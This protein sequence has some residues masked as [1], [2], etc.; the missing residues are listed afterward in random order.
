MISGTHCV[1]LPLSQSRKVA[2]G[3]VCVRMVPLDFYSTTYFLEYCVC[4]GV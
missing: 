2:S 4:M 1:A 3:S